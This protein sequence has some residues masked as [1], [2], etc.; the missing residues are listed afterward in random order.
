MRARSSREYS[1]SPRIFRS[2]QLRHAYK[3]LILLVTISFPSLN[4]GFPV[5]CIEESLRPTGE[6]RINELGGWPWS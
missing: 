6:V 2:G 3:P 1:V 5:N 4:P